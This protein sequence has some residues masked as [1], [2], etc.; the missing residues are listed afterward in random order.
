M[1]SALWGKS[2]SLDYWTALRLEEVTAPER[3]AVDLLLRVVDQYRAG[4][5]L[6]TGTLPVMGNVTKLTYLALKSGGVLE[7]RR[8]RPVGWWC[9]SVGP[10][11]A[12]IPDTDQVLSVRMVIEGE[13]LAMYETGDRHATGY[14]DS[15]LA[16]L[17]EDYVHPF[18]PD[19]P[20][21]SA[22]R[23]VQL[24]ADGLGHGIAQD[25]AEIGLGD[26]QVAGNVDYGFLQQE[27]G[28]VDD[29]PAVVRT[30]AWAARMK[31][32]IDLHDGSII[33]ISDTK[34]LEMEAR[35]VDLRAEGE[36]MRDH[37]RR[38]DDIHWVLLQLAGEQ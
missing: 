28:F 8:G 19:R 2:Q 3:K 15:R 6:H 36:R 17:P 23:M 30:S 31:G 21:G 18:A 14:H 24:D 25:H 7:V 33:R 32:D 11:A 20:A 26:F 5:Y 16:H 1:R 13:E 29:M 12:D 10:Y 34:Q 27:A 35:G 22:S 4:L 37:G 9:F 38:G